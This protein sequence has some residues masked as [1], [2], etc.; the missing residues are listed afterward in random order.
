MKKAGTGSKELYK[1]IFPEDKKPDE[2]NYV[3]FALI[4]E[5]LFSSEKEEQEALLLVKEKKV[6]GSYEGQEHYQ[7]YEEKLEIGR[8]SCRERV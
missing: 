2:E 4:E 1:E 6:T 3:D 7:N 5:Q 8:A